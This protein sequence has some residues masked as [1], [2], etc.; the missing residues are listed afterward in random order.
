MK[1]SYNY[2]Q[3]ENISDSK[4]SIFIPIRLQIK[5][6]LS[7]TSGIMGMYFL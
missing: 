7:V 2:P 1:I 6:I 4:V 5:T 3:F